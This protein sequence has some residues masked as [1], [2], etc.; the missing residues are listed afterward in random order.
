MRPS[1]LPRLAAA[2]SAAALLLGGLAVTTAPS[3]AST[4]EAAA[5]AS[6]APVGARAAKSK[7]LRVADV[8]V[9]CECGGA[10][11]HWGWYVVGLRIK[12]A[13]DGYR[14]KASIKGQK[15]AE[16][17]TA[18]GSYAWMSFSR[19]D[20]DLQPGGTYT[21]VLKEYQGRKLKRTAKPA[22]YTIPQPVAHPDK[23]RLGVLEGTDIDYLVAGRDYSV[24]F[25]GEWGQ[26]VQF[27]KGVDRYTT[28]DGEFRWYKEEDYAMPWTEH[29][30]TWDLALSPTTDQVGQKWSIYVIGSTPAPK[31]VPR[32]GITAGDPVR[33]SEWGYW[34]WVEII[35]E[36]QAA[37]IEAGQDPVQGRGQHGRAASGTGIVA[38]R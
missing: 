29:A 26:G 1:I 25:Q 6:S 21:I 38:L 3:V 15:G 35:T 2:G 33:G 8:G 22:T 24:Q 27:A 5:P 12:G 16:R 4:G 10:G 23:A 19:D 14:Y 11:Y 37:E 13:R 30:S 9:S 20:Y 28:E 31:D 17:T 36:E 32:K 7:P 18:D 34:W